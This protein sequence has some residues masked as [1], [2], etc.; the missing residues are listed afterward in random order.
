MESTWH[1]FPLKRVSPALR[2]IALP[3]H[4]WAG[5]GLE[6]AQTK[7]IIVYMF[8]S[9]VRLL[10]MMRKQSNTSH[11]AEKGIL[12][13]PNPRSL[14]MLR[15]IDQFPPILLWNFKWENLCHRLSELMVYPSF[16]NLWGSSTISDIRCFSKISLAQ[17]EIIPFWFVFAISFISKIHTLITYSL[18]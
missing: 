17:R 12:H 9:V 6:K 14:P 7:K 15:F 3:V 11:M 8:L 5:R 16:P 18:L 10:L 1:N 13:P 2:E 4:T